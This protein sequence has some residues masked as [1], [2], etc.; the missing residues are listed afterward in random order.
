MRAYA[1]LYRED[2]KS[3]GDEEDYKDRRDASPETAVVVIMGD[4]EVAEDI[5]LAD[6][7][8]IDVVG[9]ERHSAWP[10]S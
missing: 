7:V 9:I 4:G 1:W 10:L 5:F 3:R 8:A 2:C 6:H